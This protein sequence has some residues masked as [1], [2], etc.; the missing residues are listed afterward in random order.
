MPPVSRPAALAAALLLP[1]AASA[2][3]APGFSDA[4]YDVLPLAARLYLL[5]TASNMGNSSVVAVLGDEE[6]LLVDDGFGPL[7]GR[8][9]ALVDSLGG[10]PVRTIV[11]THYHWD[12]TEGNEH[13]GAGATIIAH[14]HVREA[15]AS[16]PMPATGELMAAAGRPDVTTTET[17][18]LHAGGRTARVIAMPRGGHTGGDC[19]VHFPEDGVLVVGDYWFA[20]R[21]PI[22][23][24]DD[25]GSVDGY[26]ANLRGI[27]AL[28]SDDTIVVPGH[29]GFSPDPARA[30]TLGEM[31]AWAATISD[32]VDWIRGRLDDGATVESLQADGLPERFAP[33]DARPRFVSEDRW[34]AT[35]AADR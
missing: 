29:G 19:V 9:A 3:A 34:I 22:I 33:F 28:G 13:F 14:D 25:G 11:N 8:L 6:T 7:A 24:L 23:D 4:D 27:L 26:L 31:R 17:L 18:T 35:V 12:H 2:P 16:R 10:G 21:W 5:R 15:L 32:S 1:F 30:R 20:D